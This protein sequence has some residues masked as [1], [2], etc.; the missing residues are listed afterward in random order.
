[1][2]RRRLL[3]IAAGASA[4]G[5]TGVAGSVKAATGII[6]ENWGVVEIE[7]AGP[8]NP[9][10]PPDQTAFWV[11]VGTHYRIFDAPAKQQLAFAQVVVDF[12][13]PLSAKEMNR[14]ILEAAVRSAAS[15]GVTV[16]I[17]N[18]LLVGGFTH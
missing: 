14:T 13:R 4:F 17:D 10:N 6:Q 16:E 1:M 9:R 12:E 8:G 11:G 5:L 7:G 18:L 2:N 3:G 15:Q